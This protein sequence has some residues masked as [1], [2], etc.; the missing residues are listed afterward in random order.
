MQL[1]ENVLTYKVPP[2]G[3]GYLYIDIARG[4]SVVGRKLYRQHGLWTVL[5]VNVY[6]EATNPPHT[7]IPYEIAF[8]G[9]A[10]NWVTRNA[11]VKGYEHWKQQQRET[12][13]A[14]SPSL[15]PK[16]QDFKVFLNEGHRVAFNAG[17]ELIPTS[18]NMFG[19]DDIYMVGPDWVHSQIVYEIDDG[20]GHLSSKEPFL[21]I[22]G[23]D[24]DTSVSDI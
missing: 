4:M 24:N 18:G 23:P 6:T 1:T 2:A 17:L 20:A 8:S 15:K 7:G 22:I 19:G 21:H 10:R 14:S 5:G 9:A 13:R 12:L 3:A 16:W 11:L